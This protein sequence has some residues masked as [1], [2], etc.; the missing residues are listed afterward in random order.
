MTSLPRS[1]LP[2]GRLSAGALESPPRALPLHAPSNAPVAP[3][4]P[5][6]TAA[7]I[8]IGVTHEPCI[9]NDASAR[10]PSCG[11]EGA[12]ERRG[13]S[14]KKRCIESTGGTENRA[15]ADEPWA[16]PACMTD[17]RVA[18][19][20]ERNKEPILEILREVLP[21]QG[22]V[23]EV[24]SG[25]GQHAAFFARTLSPLVWQPSDADE[26]ALASI[27]AYCDEAALG[28]LRSPLLL[29][30]SA[31]SWPIE[32]ADAVVS[33]NMIH[34][35]PWAACLGLFDGSARILPDEAP[36][37][38]YGPFAIDGDFIAASNVEFDRRLRSE[39]AAW[40]VRE[41]R[42]VERAAKERGF[43]LDRVV[44]RPANNQVV[45]FRRQGG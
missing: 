43:R 45:V 39:N 41:L 5:A 2:Q 6:T 42:D 22:L 35:A 19:A 40:G 9:S 37:V 18:P 17:K 13:G 12:I 23:L 10:G 11:R 44:A 27:R 1:S 33:I 20:A 8:E 14:G 31:T 21:E 36:V 32:R 3:N 15:A 34:I 26:G 38:L 7:C 25:S 16:I 28:N 30:A 4:A 24:A 29:D